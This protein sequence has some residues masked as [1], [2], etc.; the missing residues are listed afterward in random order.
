MKIK[1]L[2]LIGLFFSISILQSANTIFVSASAKT[3]TDNS[4]K[5][6]DIEALNSVEEA[7]C[8]NE[9]E[10]G[11]TNVIGGL[12]VVRRIESQSEFNAVLSST[13]LPQAIIYKLDNSLNAVLDDAINVSIDEMISSTNNKIIPVFDIN[14]TEKADLL[15]DY[16][17]DKKYYDCF[18]LSE[19]SSVVKY[20]KNILPNVSSVIDYQNRLKDRDS[21]SKDDM[22]DIR[23]DI[24]KNYGN[25]AI[26]PVSLCNH[27]NVQYLYDSI[28]NV[29]SIVDSD[30]KVD[31]LKSIL[32]GS[33][34]VITDYTDALYDFATNE[35]KEYTMT[36][37]PLNI[38]H[39]GLPVC[40]PENTLE[41]AKLA[42]E[43]GADVIEL[44][45]YQTSDDQIVIM[46][47]AS[48][49]RT[50]DS[51]L[52]V[53]NFPL[54]TLQNLYCN[55]GF[56]NTEYRNCRI[57]S[58]EEYCKEFHDKDVRLFIEIKSYKDSIIS[59]T[60]SLIEKYDMYDQVSFISFI[61]KQLSNLNEVWPEATTGLLTNGILDENSSQEDMLQVRNTVGKYNATLNP[62]Y[63]GY[64]ENALLAS[65]SRG[66]SVYPWPFSNVSQYS[67][68]FFNGYSGLTG[69]DCRALSSL[70][71]KVIL[72]NVDK[73]Y[74]IGD[75]LSLDASILKYDRT[76]ENVD[77]VTINV[78]SDDR[79]DE[80]NGDKI[81][82]SSAGNIKFVVNYEEHFNGNVYT[83][84]SDIID[85]N[86]SSE[87]HTNNGNHKKGCSGS[88]GISLLFVA[89]ISASASLIFV[90][91]KRKHY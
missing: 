20:F 74:C 84:Y 21:L 46:H 24:H 45:I 39:R 10:L 64:G 75:T 54:S 19:E 15:A 18:V 9:V 7:P 89:F 36:R 88:V 2:S 3:E 31:L 57:P 62:G 5:P 53:E 63:S 66:I 58:L 61:E 13:N 86:I 6:C 22:I 60:K 12:N 49:G 25:V 44:D 33:I 11:K 52:F 51:N 14:S 27:D 28:V 32:S 80:I 50:C 30:S 34:G 85:M 16:L 87:S 17:K 35:I 73:E 67:A 79:N 81:T 83:L 29:W 78:L 4:I 41:G 26:L 1:F 82:F 47:D 48:T 77:N 69:D 42:Y 68:F 56:E 72:N 90:L 40:A 71:K 8:Y 23:K 43:S 91:L 65:L 37:L 55:V 59:L 70:A 38:G 76:Y